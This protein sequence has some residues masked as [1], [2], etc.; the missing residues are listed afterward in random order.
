[1]IL[2]SHPHPNLENGQFHM[3][4]FHVNEQIPTLNIPLANNDFSCL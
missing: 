4:G 2:V 1:M 3:Y